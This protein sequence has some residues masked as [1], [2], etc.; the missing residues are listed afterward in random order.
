MIKQ[1]K[2]TPN[3]RFQIILKRCIVNFKC[4]LIHLRL[5]FWESVP[6]L[7]NMAG[8]SLNRILRFT[9]SLEEK[10]FHHSDVHWHSN[11]YTDLYVH[12]SSIYWSYIASNI[13]FYHAVKH[14]PMKHSSEQESAVLL[15]VLL[16]K[17]DMWWD[18]RHVYSTGTSG[19]E[20]HVSHHVSHMMSQ[21]YAFRSK[22]K[23]RAEP[24]LN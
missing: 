4:I 7:N 23:Y 19:I 21:P 18:P 8:P 13:C 11:N 6:S 22:L 12:C 2:F 1:T 9:A 14:K 15:V 5:L 24:I 17:W 10:K 20:F 3:L 16:Q